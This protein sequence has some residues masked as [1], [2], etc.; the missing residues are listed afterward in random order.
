MSFVLSSG[1]CRTGAAEQAEAISSTR[2]EMSWSAVVTGLWCTGTVRAMPRQTGVPRHG[3]EV[4]GDPGT[5]LAA[6]ARAGSGRRGPH[7]SG[8]RRGTSRCRA[9]GRGR[10]VVVD[11]EEG[12]VAAAG[13]PAR[14]V[15]AEG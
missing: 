6:D 1:R 14:G 11:D 2:W 10:A 12:L 13:E 9:D 4:A 8:R 7:A 3:G 5:D 15:G